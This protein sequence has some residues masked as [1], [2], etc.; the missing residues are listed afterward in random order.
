[1]IYRSSL[2]LSACVLYYYIYILIIYSKSRIAQ[3]S[4]SAKRAPAPRA[5]AADEELAPEEPDI[6]TVMHPKD[7]TRSEKEKVRRICTPKSTTGRL[8]V[9]KDI[10]EM[11]NS[12]KGREKL[13]S[14]WCKSGG[15]KAGS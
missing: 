9:P 8:E 2:S 13:L 7:M 3:A 1:M 12:E 6:P 5:N 15:L 10:H 4:D 11:W 14:L